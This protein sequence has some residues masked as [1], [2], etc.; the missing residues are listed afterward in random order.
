[1]M[2][3]IQRSKTIWCGLSLPLAGWLIQHFNGGTL[4][5]PV[6]TWGPLA[7]AAGVIALR[8]GTTSCLFCGR[9]AHE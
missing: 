6:Q 2:K 9:H 5:A 8:L 4:P 1:M 3:A 7:V